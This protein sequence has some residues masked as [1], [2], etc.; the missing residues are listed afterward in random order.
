M[1]KLYYKNTGEILSILYKLTYNK[2]NYE[3]YIIDYVTLSIYDPLI[4]DIKKESIVHDLYFGG[5]CEILL[6][7]IQV[8][9]IN[10]NINQYY[11]SLIF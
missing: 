8:M 10:I 4:K 5:I 11:Y 3:K 2:Y 7:Y 1:L 6:N 9:N